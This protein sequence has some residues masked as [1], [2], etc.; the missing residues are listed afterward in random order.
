MSAVMNSTSANGFHPTG[1][2]RF[3]DKVAI[4]TG[5]SRGIGRAIAVAFARE[6]ADVVVNY[7][8]KHEAAEEVASEI[9]ALGRRCVLVAGSVGDPAV[10]EALAQR[11]LDDLGRIDI[12][13]NNAGVGKDGYLMMLADSTWSSVVDVNLH[14]SFYCTRAVARSMV[15]Q[16]SG[17]IV[18]MSSSSGIRGRAGQVSYAA[19]KGALLGLTTQ[20]ARELGPKGVR[21]NALAPGF[22]ETEMIDNLLGLP[23]IRDA[24]I[25]ATPMRRLGNT[26]D[27]A[28]ATLFLA[29]PASSFVTGHVMLI[30]GGLLML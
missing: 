12:L 13:V 20:F 19:T 17:V 3:L 23:G 27:I 7:A 26:E 21:V 14:G 18:N 29:S 22:V 10:A 1:G 8:S 30:N 4:V 9:R 15:A 24:F 6:G 2:S 16:G 25:A 11:A 5:A 28:E